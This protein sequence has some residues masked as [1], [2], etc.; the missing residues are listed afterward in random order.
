MAVSYGWTT[1]GLDMAMNRNTF[2]FLLALFFGLPAVPEAA[3]L[4][5]NRDIR[6]ILSDKC[7]ACHGFDKK[8]READLRLDVAEGAFAVTSGHQA[9]KPGDPGASEAWKRIITEDEDDI[10]PPPDSHKKL[11]AGERATIKRWI[12]QG[13]KYE[14]HWAF[15]APEKTDVPEVA[16]AKNP[17]DAFLLER[18][19]KEGLEFSPAADR[20]TL[21]R[22][23]T[24]DLTG[25]PPTPKE[26]DA[27][28]ADKSPDAY[29]KLVVDLQSRPAY[30]ENMARYWLD[31]ARYAD[32]HG[33]HLD[34][35]RS[36][37]PYRDWVVKALNENIP[38]DDFTRWQLAGDLLAKP[39]RDQQIASGFNRCNVTTSEGGSINEEF[40]YRYALD[41]TTTTIEVWM[42]MSAGCAVC[43]DHK[44]DPI[45]T[46]DYYSMYAFFN[47]AA[48]PAMDGN[49]IDTPPILKLSTKEDEARLRKLDAGIAVVDEKIEQALSTVKY[50]DPATLDPA[51]AAKDIETV[52]F[53][54]GFPAG[55][56]PAASGA[57]LEIVRRSEG[58]RVFSG[59]A[60]LRRKAGQRVEQD[61]Y[62]GGAD[63]K[64]PA[65]GKI[66][67]NCFLDPKDPP[68]A[69]MLQF[70]IGGWKHRAIW[71]D[72][73]KIAFGKL[74]TNEKVF[75]GKLPKTGEWVRLEFDAKKLGIKGGQKVGGYAFTQFGGTMNWDRLGVMSKVDTAKDQEWSYKVW[76]EKN[77]GKRNNLL[78]EG[79]RQVV[80]G[81]K[82]EKWSKK[83]AEQIRTFWL[84]KI[85]AGNRDLL[86]PFEEEKAPLE[87]EKSAIEKKIPI[88]FVMA[89]MP[90]QRD[91]FVMIRG[92]YDKPGEKVTRAVPAIFPPLPPK[93]KDRDYNRL[94]F[95]NWLVSG[96]HPLTARVTVNRFWQQI[97]GIG[98]VKTSAD[99]GSQ[100]EPPSH[101]E[102]LDWLAIDFVENG[103]DM[104]E[105][106][107]LLVTS[108]AYRQSSRTTPELLERDPEN[109][110]LAHATRFRLDAEVLR[111][112]V[113]F[114]SGLLVQKIGGKGVNPYQPPNIW[115]PVAF[116]GSNTKNYKQGAGEDLYRKSLYTFFKRTAPSPFM[117]TFDAPNR[118]QS[119]SL[120]GRSNTPLQALQL[121]ND[122]QH[123]EAARNLAQ[124]MMKEGGE[125]V[126]Q[127]IAWAWRVATSR[128]VNDEELTIAKNAFSQHLN[129]YESDEKSA[130]EAV[131]YGESKRD[132][133]I[134]ASE[135]AAYTMVA[136]LIMNLDE[137]VV[138]N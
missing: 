18:L 27:F 71:G 67:V 99:F 57:P 52:W 116:G 2:L 76:K 29:E 5:F 41:R 28:L 12:E 93:P 59:N 126:D 46:K 6:P 132:E 89:D 104:K 45:S 102:L 87:K 134:K 105:F 103:W 72:E 43:H 101:P 73:K 131:A 4:T 111:D 112:Q 63:F 96:D 56:K 50:I 108:D 38:F 34:N 91:S 7:F 23:V 129:R 122:V 84:S 13:A 60:S 55:T 21:I 15:L 127:R 3:D 47:S 58:G 30:G 97:F 98:L 88:T 70:N 68:Q 136:N 114:M 137:V 109:R 16:G 125:T 20:A 64:M 83:E 1:Y 135:L 100:G 78:P 86:L 35:E 14:Q 37:W 117:T 80:R 53:E 36:M 118:E 9:I 77:Q 75:M 90:K 95:A 40:I 26:V 79:L 107:R 85:Y 49:K 17:I 92:A 133:K 119:C 113:L 48:D 51:P 62:A 94:D 115:E 110:L 81:K 130:A 69:I 42:G 121:M 54:D 106:I 24:L 65:R 128:A 33:L 123:F 8:K 66:F 19:R 32:T 31:L 25:L 39:T 44:F 120:R 124:R 74:G 138:R 11:D 82:V 22:R 61:Y 10:M